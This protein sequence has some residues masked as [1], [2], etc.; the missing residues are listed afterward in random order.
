MFN[1]VAFGSIAANQ[2][3]HEKMEK[4]FQKKISHKYKR[5]QYEWTLFRFLM[6][7]RS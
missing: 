7:G 6:I 1:W 4:E 2:D 3:I 5:V